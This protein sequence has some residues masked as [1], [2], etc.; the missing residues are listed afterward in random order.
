VSRQGSQSETNSFFNRDIK[1]II[2]TMDG[3]EKVAGEIVVIINK[4]RVAG[5]TSN[6][7]VR[8]VS[9]ATSMELRP[10]V[11][12]VEGRMFNPGL[13]E[14]VVSR[15]VSQRF[16][17][18]KIGDTLKIGRTTWKVVG[19]MDASQSAHDSEIWGDYNEIAQEFERPVYSSLLVRVR[20]QASIK[21]V[22]DRIAGDR[23]VKLDTFGEREFFESQTSSALPLQILGYLVAVIMAIGSCFAVMNTMYAATAY[24]TREIATLRV[25]GYRRFS[26][27]LSFVFESVLLSVCGGI[28]GCL[29]ALPV[30]GITTGT[31]NFTSFSEVVFK[32]QITPG[33][34]LQG[35]VFAAVMGG[36]GGFLPGVRAS[37]TPI[38]RALRTEV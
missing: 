29:L 15:S 34:M 9:A 35:I 19:I 12:I 1:G 25:L 32:F 30:N 27:L 8:G 17:D 20:D 7:M 10:S 6:V 28:V 23:R 24:R 36:I 14:L 18:A 38:V 13:R 31:T 22:Q 2:E 37:V 16:R 3:V 21:A 4:T 11:K 5:D 26:I 33:L